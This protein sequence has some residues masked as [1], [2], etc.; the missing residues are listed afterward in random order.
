MIKYFIF[1]YYILIYYFFY[2]LGFIKKNY[3]LFFKEI[4][5]FL[6]KIVFR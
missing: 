5:I 4:V 6:Y 2:L 1:V 3:I